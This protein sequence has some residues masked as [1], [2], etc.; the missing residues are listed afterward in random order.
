MNKT[1]D[2]ECTAKNCSSHQFWVSLHMRDGRKT[3]M[4]LICSQCGNR[5]SFGVGK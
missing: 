1:V 5:I 4:D 2:L 3:R